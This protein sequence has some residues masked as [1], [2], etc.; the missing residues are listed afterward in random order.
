[1][2]ANHTTDK[3]LIS[4]IHRIQTLKRTKQSDFKKTGN[5]SKPTFLKR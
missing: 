1:M 3:G 5:G 2:F 4:K